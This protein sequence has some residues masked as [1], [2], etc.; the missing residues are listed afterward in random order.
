MIHMTCVFLYMYELLLFVMFNLL[1]WLPY[2]IGVTV[3]LTTCI[4]LYD[5]SSQFDLWSMYL[6]VLII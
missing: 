4:T 3:T 1:L 2:T 5:V 6:T